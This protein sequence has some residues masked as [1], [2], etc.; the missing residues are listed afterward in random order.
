MMMIMIKVITEPQFFFLEVD[1][2]FSDF[3]TMDEFV[4]FTSYRPLYANECLSLH[5]SQVGKGS[6]RVPE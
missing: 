5:I 2:N 6:Y 4:S 3:E 1:H